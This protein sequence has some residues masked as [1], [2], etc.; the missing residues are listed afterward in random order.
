MGSFVSVYVK[1]YL[2]FLTVLV[3]LG[4]ALRQY[5]HEELVFNLL[6]RCRV[7]TRRCEDFL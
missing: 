6:L 2:V 5:M 7:G 3:G 4:K 1:S